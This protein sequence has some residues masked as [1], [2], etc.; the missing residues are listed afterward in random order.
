MIS[1]LV[2]IIYITMLM[3][4]ADDVHRFLIFFNVAGRRDPSDEKL[5]LI[6]TLGFV[7]PDG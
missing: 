6:K 4:A 1:D 2:V 7:V 3:L 5:S